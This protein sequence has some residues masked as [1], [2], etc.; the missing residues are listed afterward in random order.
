MSQLKSFLG[1]LN[2]LPNLSTYLDPSYSLLQKKSHW[3]RGEKQC[4][5]FEKA[6]TLLTSSCV[7]THYDPIKPL[8]LTCDASPYRLGAVLFHK[9]DGDD[10]L[11][12]AFALCSL[13]STDKHYSQ[14]HNEDLLLFLVLNIFAV[15]FK[16]RSDHKPLQN[17][18]GE[19]KG[20]PV[21]AFAGV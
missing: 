3:L 18:L 20:I 5:A 11:P 13:A 12:I 16:I 19:R 9:E 15:H 14:I 10:E 1:I 8:I 4:T 21:M 17:L 2:F 6:K 7:L